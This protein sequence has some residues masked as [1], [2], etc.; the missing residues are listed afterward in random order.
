MQ[1]PRGC[2]SPALL[3][4]GLVGPRLWFCSV[5]GIAGVWGDSSTELCGQGWIPK[6]PTQKHCL[7]CPPGLLPISFHTY[8]VL[9]LFLEFTV[10]LRYF[11][12]FLIHSIF[13]SSF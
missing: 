11:F 13:F 2:A 6:C 9:S 3:G 12:L 4:H 5:C 8:L 10:D 1:G 7:S